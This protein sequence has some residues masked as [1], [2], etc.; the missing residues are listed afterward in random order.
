MSFWSLRCAV[1]AVRAGEV[2]AYPTEA[3]FGLGCDPFNEE[4]VLQLLAIKRRPWQKGVILIASCITQLQP[5]IA[6]LTTEQQDKLSATWPG[7]MTWLVPAHP[8]TPSYLTGT[9]A[10]IAVRVT[11]HPTARRLCQQLDHPLVSTSANRTG[12]LPARTHHQVRRQLPMIEHIVTASCGK[13][14]QPSHIRDLTT[15]K[16]IR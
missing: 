2:I 7:H 13:A 6:P 15:G 14:E 1:Q 12:G 11:A 9:H 3:V 4:A 10:T 8:D 5:F 16:V